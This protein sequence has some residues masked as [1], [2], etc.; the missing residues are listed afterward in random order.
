MGTRKSPEPADK[1]VCATALNRHAPVECDAAAAGPSDTAAL[2]RLR[3]VVIGFVE[4]GTRGAR[5]SE[6][7]D[8]RPVLGLQ[9]GV[10]AAKF[11]SAEIFN[12]LRNTVK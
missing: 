7:P 12:L 10:G 5:P 2:R 1:N 6:C 4:V 8:V 9:T 11:A 3:D